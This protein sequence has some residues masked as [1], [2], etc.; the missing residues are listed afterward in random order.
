MPVSLHRIPD[1][2][3]GGPG[4]SSRP[5]RRPGRFERSVKAMSKSR[6]RSRYRSRKGMLLRACVG[7]LLAAA[8]LAGLYALGRSYE[9]NAYPEERQQASESFGRLHAVEYD[10]AIYLRRPEVTTV[11]VMGVDREEGDEPEGFRDGG[12]A[13]FLMLVALDHKNNTV[14]RLQI[15]RDAVTDVPVVGVLGNDAGTRRM[16]IC[17]AHAYGGSEED[18]CRHTVQAAANL[19]AGETAQQYMSLMLDD[20]GVLNSALGGVT[21]T[22][23]EDL[24]A[25]DPAFTSGAVVT[26][27]DA[28]AE[29]LVRARMSVGDGTNASRM[30]RQ[31][32][33]MAA[34]LSQAKALMKEDPEFAGK[35][36]DTMKDM[37]GHRSFQR[38]QMVN[39]LNQIYSYDILPVE[40]LP[41]E[42]TIGADGFVEFH[43]EEKATAEWIL[44]TLYEPKK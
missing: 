33:F 26:L 19:L 40:T 34:A 2:A 28:Q 8:A 7:L 17:L 10:G 42:Y 38:G 13:D 3:R 12:Q 22:I 25:V 9:Q 5:A 21:V 18:R 6:S 1:P 41:G 14:S 24:T 32:V 27:T 35:L 11:L 16:Q 43:A 30:A 44:R 39:Q 15:D 4:I 29:A 36:F 37:G 20:I 31:R 23:P